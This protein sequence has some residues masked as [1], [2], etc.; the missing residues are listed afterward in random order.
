MAVEPGMRV[1]DLGC[2]RAITSVFLARE[3]GA[4]VW[5]ADMWIDPTPNWKPVARRR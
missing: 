5:A 2:G 1:L 3:F 4:R